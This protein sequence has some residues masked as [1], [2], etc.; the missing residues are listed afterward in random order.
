MHKDLKDLDRAGCSETKTAALG[1]S[2]ER[3][4]PSTR[5][6]T[7]LARISERR[8]QTFFIKKFIS[9]DVCE[10]LKSNGSGLFAILSHDFEQSFGQIVSVRVKS[11]SNT[12]LVLSGHIKREKGSLP[13][14]VRRS[15]TTLLKL[16]DSFNHNKARDHV[17]KLNISVQ[18]Q[19]QD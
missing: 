5:V 2:D 7:V 16:P 12:D 11:V 8:C 17:Y 4:D 15:K 9:N 14:Y 18:E 1:R 19:D 13:V 3:L 10:R 6:L